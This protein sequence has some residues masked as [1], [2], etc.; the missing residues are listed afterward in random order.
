M[1]IIIQRVNQAR[2][3]VES[4]L[5]GEIQRGALVF[6]G[7][8]KDDTQK[9]ADYLVKKIVD[10]RMFDDSEGNLNLSAKDIGAAFLVVSQFTLYGNCT[11]G[12]RPSFDKAAAPPVAEELYNYFLNALKLQEVKVESGMFRAMMQVELIND[13]PVTFILDSHDNKNI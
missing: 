13:G 12:R 5:V 6:L 1:K 9:E 2:V 10:L 11:K 8:S 4:K 7:I 3:T